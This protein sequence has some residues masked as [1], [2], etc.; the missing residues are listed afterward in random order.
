MFEILLMI[1]FLVA[2]RWTVY[3]YFEKQEPIIR[4]WL[5]FVWT[6]LSRGWYRLLDRLHR[7]FQ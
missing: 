6:Y 5:K 4:P 1:Y 2:L 7:S 3:R